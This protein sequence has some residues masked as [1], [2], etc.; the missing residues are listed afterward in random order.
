MGYH[1]RNSQLRVVRKFARQIRNKSHL[2]K[3]RIIILEHILPTTEEFIN[4]LQE[5]GCEFFQV[6][7]KPYSIDQDVYNRLAEK[8][9]LVRKTYDELENTNYLSTLIERAI[10]Q[11]IKDGKKIV[12]ID[13][14]GYFAAPLSKLKT[15]QI[16]FIAGVVEDTTFGHNR[17]LLA[18][19]NINIPVFSVAR[20]NLK[21]IEARFVGRDAVYAMDNIL[22]RSGISISGRNALVIGYGMIG[23]NVARTLRSSDLN[24]YVYDKHDHKDLSAFIDGF[25]IHKKRELLKLAD[26][27][28]LATGDPNGALSFNEIEE[29]KDNVILVSVGSKDTEYDLKAIN[30]QAI[31]CEKIDHHL[32]MFTLSNSKEVISAKEGTAINFTMPSIPIEILDLVFSEIL[33]CTL[34]I[35]KKPDDYPPGKLYE[36]HADHLDAVSKDWLR[37]VNS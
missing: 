12:I 26:I 31:S 4:I 5:V 23:K 27:I 6:I 33:L 13:V 21:E 15:E 16:E 7:A 1:F 11:S 22:R 20:S 18:I 28:F 9:D 17:Y 10:N 37:F 36:S 32:M 2:E 29:C 30:E 3:T 34:L 14:G 8:V 19:E 25:H 24:V 35:L